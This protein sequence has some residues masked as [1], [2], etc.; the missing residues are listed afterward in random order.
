[1]K[2]WRTIRGYLAWT[3]E[4]GSVHYDVM[5]TLIL[6]F[7]F[8]APL[9]VNFKD[10][11][12]ERTLHQ[13]GGVLILPDGQGGVIYQVEASAVS[14][15][16]G[17]DLNDALAR[18]IEPIE[19]SEVEINRVETVKDSSGRVLAYKAWVRR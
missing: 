1:M 4:R 14:G 7:I 19:R 9:R 6:L 11:P 3:Y 10:K 15:A 5:V 8:L 2:I 13:N 16:S 12:V 17:D 18:V